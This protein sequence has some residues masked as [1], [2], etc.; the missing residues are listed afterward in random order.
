MDLLLRN[1]PVNSFLKTDLIHPTVAYLITEMIEEQKNGKDSPVYAPLIQ[2]LLARLLPS[3]KLQRN[4]GTDYPELTYRISNYISE[5]F[6]ETL[7]LGQLAQ[8]MGISKSHLSHLFTEKMGQNFSSYLSSIRL[9]YACQLLSETDISVTE[10]SEI[11]GFESQRTFFRAFHN[12]FRITP[13]KYRQ[14]SK[15]DA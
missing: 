10:I 3:L 13:L 9:S 5:H 2:L 15:R 1:H 12:R 7:T 8:Q 6:R 14:A 4:K 11:S